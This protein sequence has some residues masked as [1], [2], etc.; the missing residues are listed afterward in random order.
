MVFACNL[1]GCATFSI[2]KEKYYN[3]VLAKVGNTKITR[4]DLLNA[5]NSYG[6]TYFGSDDEASALN[7]T[8]NML[9]ERESLYQYALSQGDLYKPTEFQVNE[10]VGKIFDSLD[11]QMESYVESAQSGMVAGLNMARYLKYRRSV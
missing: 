4:F 1:A 7:E 2:N 10:I 5:Y 11:S 3:E 6:K 9:I 8:L